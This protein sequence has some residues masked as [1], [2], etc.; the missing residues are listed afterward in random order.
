VSE[1]RRMLTVDQYEYIR[2]AHRVYGKKIKELRR[3][4][5]HSKN[6]IRKVLRGEYQGYSER[7][8]QPYP[9]LGPYLHIIDDWLKGD[10]ERPKK[11]R[12]TA[13]RIFD[14]LVEEHNFPGKQS[15]VRRYV[16]DAKIRIGVNAP[17]VF[18]PSDPELAREAEVDWGT[19]IAIIAGEQMKLKFFCMR[20]KYSGKHFVR[21][22]PCERRQ[23]FLDAH[24]HAFEFFGGVF[25]TIIYDN[26]TTAVQKVLVGKD[27]IEQESFIKFRAYYNFTPRFCNTD[28]PHEKGGVEGIVGYVRRNY[29]VPVPQ[30]QSLEELNQKLLK[31]CLLYGDHVIH[32]R[33]H[34]VNELFEKEKE[35]LLVLPPVPFKNVALTHAKVG[36]YSTVI[37]DE[38]HYSVPNKYAGL[39]VRIILSVTMVEVFYKAQ[40]IA[41][42]TR[43]YGKN[44]WQLNPDHYLELIKERPASFD[45]ARPIQGWRKSWPES[46]EKLLDRLTTSHGKTKGVK[47][48]IPI[49]E[50]YR[51]HNALDVEA[52]V[53]LALEYHIGSA[54][55]VKHILFHSIADAV[56]DSLGGWPETPTPDISVYSQLGGI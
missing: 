5:G 38:N 14:R 45:T 4:T 50:L 48:F 46:L 47:E 19:V 52:A 51:N 26:L 12:H 41:S 43:L 16:R 8:S 2:I 39:I 29:M 27:R 23:A 44:K 13:K 28:S 42:H 1:E 33:E 31:K 35:S 56:P 11:Q 10:K 9:V 6:T 20:S 7:K 54:E 36:T 37:A 30:A 49:L 3:E 22:Y 32:G 17:K 40:R 55:G 18:I 34:T 21:C 53:E 15:N 24:M 25:R